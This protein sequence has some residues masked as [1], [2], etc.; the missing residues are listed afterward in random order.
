MLLML[1][2]DSYR[3]DTPVHLPI[4]TCMAVAPADVSGAAP[5][6]TEPVAPAISADQLN[7]ATP[8]AAA[9]QGD[10]AD[11]LKRKLDLERQDR[12]KLGQTNQKLNDELRDL[13]AQI[14]AVQEQAAQ[15]QTATLED[16]GQFKT[17]WEQAQATIADLKQQIVNLS[18]EKETISQKVE[19]ERIQNEALAVLA[20]Q[21]VTAPDQLLTILQAK[22]GLRRGETGTVEV[23][24]GG[25]STPLAD[26]LQAM[27]Q[28]P[29][30]QHHFSASG[31]RGMGA[32]PSS[33]SVA[34]GMTNPW[35]KDTFNWTQQL[36]LEQQNP[37][38]AEAFKREAARG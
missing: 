1:A 19:Q 34:P 9:Q 12:L 3:Y 31:Q 24:V 26:Q 30:W 35:R 17:L 27:R 20:Q 6:S 5:P 8:P 13:R 33:S 22:N 14:K 2:L 10:D 7:P 25:A 21:G 11:F 37:E 4:L 36:L 29:E 32:S 15:Q 18:T 38:L 23:V 16:Q 28:A